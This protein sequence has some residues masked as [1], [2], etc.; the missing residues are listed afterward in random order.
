M[1]RR[2]HS[3]DIRGELLNKKDVRQGHLLPSVPSMY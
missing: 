3:T 2:E 1:Q